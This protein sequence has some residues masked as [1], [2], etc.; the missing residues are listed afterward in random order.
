MLLLLLLLLLLQ[1]APLLIVVVGGGGVS[2]G[3]PRQLLP[4][5]LQDLLLQLLSLGWHPGLVLTLP[6]QPLRAPQNRLVPRTVLFGSINVEVGV[7]GAI[8]VAQPRVELLLRIWTACLLIIT[9]I[10]FGCPA[11]T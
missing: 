3:T 9:F 11:L 10:A 6:D 7:Q 5:P 1:M 4:Q 8:T 2:V